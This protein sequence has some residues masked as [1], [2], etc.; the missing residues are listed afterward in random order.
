MG[1]VPFTCK[2]RSARLRPR[3]SHAFFDGQSM[4]GH[5]DEK[6]YIRFFQRSE[7]RKK[8]RSIIERANRQNAVGVVVD[9]PQALGGG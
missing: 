3:T 4:W 1:A 2:V 6:L 9:K 7:N 8:L 5:S